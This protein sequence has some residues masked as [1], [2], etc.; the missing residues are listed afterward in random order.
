MIQDEL[1]EKLNE[2]VEKEEREYQI[3]AKKKDLED[4]EKKVQPELSAI[5]S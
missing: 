4:Y 5:I 1:E 2:Q 3:W